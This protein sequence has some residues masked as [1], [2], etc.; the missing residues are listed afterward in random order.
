M[1]TCSIC[2][3][4]CSNSECLRLNACDKCVH[5]YIC[6]KCIDDYRDR[7]YYDCEHYNCP[8]CGEIIIN[9]DM[10]DIIKVISEYTDLKKFIKDDDADKFKILHKFYKKTYNFINDDIYAYMFYLINKDVLDILFN[11]LLFNINCNDDAQLH[12]ILFDPNSENKNSIK[13]ADLT[14]YLNPENYIIDFSEIINVLDKCVLKNI[15]KIY[16]NKNEHK[17][18]NYE[19]HHVN[20]I[21]IY[22]YILTLKNTIDTVLQKFENANLDKEKFDEFKRLYKNNIVYD[23]LKSYKF[24]IPKNMR[25]AYID[26]PRYYFN[27]SITYSNIEY[28]NIYM[29]Q[30][31]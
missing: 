30:K 31:I 11:K 10:D 20:S 22:K 16:Y 9:Y 25:V 19:E 12:G 26:N 23:G 7:V 5:S 18:C 4:T 3:S 21:K 29:D 2:K 13:N 14:K 28:K 15:S 6:D 24:T 17:K 1:K 27:D 8:N